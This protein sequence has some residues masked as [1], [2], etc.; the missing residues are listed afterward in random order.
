M[1]LGVVGGPVP[2]SVPA[3]EGPA[4]LLA[5]VAVAIAF[6]LPVWRIGSPTRR[7]RRGLPGA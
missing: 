1:S 4:G 6:V 7:L 3:G 5:A 2:S